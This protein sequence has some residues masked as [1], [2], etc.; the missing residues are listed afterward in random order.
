MGRIL[1]VVRKALWRVLRYQHAWLLF[2]Q[3]AIN[4]Q[5]AYELAFEREERERQAAAFARRLARLEAD[6]PPRDEPPERGN[7]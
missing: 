4:R 2:H 6:T 1:L 3:N 5:L 7:S